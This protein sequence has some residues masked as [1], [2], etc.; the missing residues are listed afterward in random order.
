MRLLCFSCFRS[1][2]VKLALFTVFVLALQIDFAARWCFV[3]LQMILWLNTFV[4]AI[5]QWH[6]VIVFNTSPQMFLSLALVSFQLLEMS[7]DLSTKCLYWNRHRFHI[8][9]TSMVLFIL[10]TLKSSLGKFN[11]S[12]E[13]NWCWEKM[14]KHS[15]GFPNLWV[16][17]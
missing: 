10:D 17:N 4:H 8:R 5:E 1:F 14:F 9:R 7:N 11:R 2:F 16:W 3:S 15:K 6:S 12:R 13:V